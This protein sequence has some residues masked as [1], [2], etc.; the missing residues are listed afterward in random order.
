MSATTASSVLRRVADLGREVLLAELREIRC[1][2]RDLDRVVG[3][4]FG[5]GRRRLVTVIFAGGCRGVGVLV[6]V[7]CLGVVVGRLAGAGGSEQTADRQQNERRAPAPKHPNTPRIVD[8]AR[9]YIETRSARPRWP[10]A[11][12]EVGSAVDVDVGA[13]HVGVAARP[14]EGDDR[15]DLVGI[16]RPGKVGGVVEVFLDA[17]HDGVEVVGV[18]ADRPRPHLRASRSQSCPARRC[19]PGSRRPRATATGSW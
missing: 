16:T 11:S 6:A 15:P 14:H 13:R 5:V 12:A 10:L 7:D 17:A 8:R 1:D 19:S 4:A 2:Q 18:D 9:T 3:D